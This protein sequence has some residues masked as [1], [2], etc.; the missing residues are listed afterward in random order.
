MGKGDVLMVPF[1]QPMDLDAKPSLDTTL[2]CLDT[3]LGGALS[4]LLRTSEFTGALGCSATAVLPRTA[5]FTKITALGLGQPSGFRSLGVMY[6]SWGELIA[7]YTRAERCQIAVAVLPRIEGGL[8]E[9]LGFDERGMVIAAGAAR[10]LPQAT[11]LAL[12][13]GG[14]SSGARPSLLEVMGRVGN[15]CVASRPPPPSACA[16]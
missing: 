6:S 7:R 2:L 10:S 8:E 15:M 5:P 1:F 16:A 13:P 11:P 14:G 3:A 12:P 4:Q 9:A